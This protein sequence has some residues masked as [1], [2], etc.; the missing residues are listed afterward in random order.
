VPRRKISFALRVTDTKGDVHGRSVDRC[1]G[2]TSRSRSHVR[3]ESYVVC[4]CKE[5]VR[6]REQLHGEHLTTSCRTGEKDLKRL[7]FILIR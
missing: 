7:S 1:S 5:I 2:H 4:L 3:V 6:F